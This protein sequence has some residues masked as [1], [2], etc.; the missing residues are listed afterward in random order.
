MKTQKHLILFLLF[1]FIVSCLDNNKKEDTIDKEEMT[2][3]LKDDKAYLEKEAGR[4]VD[5]KY[6]A[7]YLGSKSLHLKNKHFSILDLNEDGLLDAVA[8][9]GF[10]NKSDNTFQETYIEYYEND[11]EALVFK[12]SKDFS[13]YIYPEERISTKEVTW[14]DN[15]VFTK[16]ITPDNSGRL[17]MFE[18][19]KEG[20]VDLSNGKLSYGVFINESNGNK[21]AY[22]DDD[23]NI[24]EEN[25]YKYVTAESGLIYRDEPDGEA[26]GKLPYGTEVHI[27]GKTDVEKTIYDDGEEITGEWVQI[28]IDEY[29]EETAYIFNGFL[30]EE[31]NLNYAK[32]I[33]NTPIE[34]EEVQG[35]GMLLPGPY[36]MYNETLGAMDGIVV[37]KITDVTILQKTKYKRPENE[38]DE[39]CKWSNYAKI[40]YKGNN[41]IVFGATL[42]NISH[43]TKIEWK[44][45][46]VIYLVEA[47]NY[48]V[49]AADYDGLTGCDDYSDV[50]IKQNNSY[51]HIYHKPTAKD[52]NLYEIFFVHDDGMSEDIASFE[53]KNDTII[54]NME[55]G[56]QEGTG[57]YKLNVFNENGWKCIET[58]EKRDY[59][60]N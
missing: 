43:T 42:L 60:S 44:T 15:I 25:N 54:F 11:G 50:F 19:S 57:S 40:N 45:D 28:Q 41:I 16:E 51:S 18:K 4:K 49:E 47:E 8:F 21:D 46:E 9:L 22:N 2:T 48:T 24:S 29:S 27:I 5:I 33:L 59:S 14:V 17:N 12:E 34:F 37:D 1:M 23:Y 39:Y 36:Y 32:R 6:D 7:N 52:K 58:D 20:A 38:E 3:F 13:K 55:Q 26:L 35:K 53:V 31:Y 56:F 10:F 30:D